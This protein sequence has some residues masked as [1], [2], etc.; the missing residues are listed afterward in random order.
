MRKILVVVAACFLVIPLRAQNK[1]S[2]EGKFTM[3]GYIK[4]SLSG[5]SIIG[6]SIIINGASKGVTSNQYGFYSITLDSG[7][8]VISVS[9][10]SYVSKAIRVNLD[11]NLTFDFDLIPKSASLNEVVIYSK[12]RDGNVKNAQMGKIDL[13]I[14]Q[15]K[16]IPALLG[17]VDI[18]KA[19][20]LL[21]G[22]Q[23]AGEGNAGF[24]VRGGGPDQNLIMLDDAVVYNTGHLFGFFSIF[25]SDAIKDVSL[26]K[27]GM[28]AQYGG[29]LSSVLDISMKDGNMNKTEME[30]GIGLIASRFSIQ[31]PIKK[32]KASYM[33]SVRR[34]YVDALV[35]P[36]IKKSSSFHGSGYYFYDLNAKVNYRFSEKD[37][38]YLSGY[39]GR[40]VFDFNN[41][42]QSFKTNIPWG[43]STATL[44][45]N[46]VFNRRLFANTTLV[47]NDYKFRFGAEQDNLAFSLSSG[48]RDGNMKIDFDYY[49]LPQHKVKFGGLITYHKFVPN[50][51]SGHQDSVVFHPN[52]ENNKYAIENALYLQDDWEISEKIKINYGLRWSG[53]TQIGPYTKYVR[54]INQNKTDSTV[55]K[56]FQPVKTYGGPEPRFTIRY[57]LNDETS[58]K[59]AVTRNYQYIHLVSNSGSTLPTDLWV[60]S[61]Y[62]VKPQLS[63]L[64]SAGIFK[65]FKNNEYETSL[66]L[67]YKDMKNQIEYSNGYMPSLTDPES[68]FVFGKG[69]SYGAEVFLNKVRGRFNGWIGYTLS[70]TWR[71]FKDLNNGEKYPAKYDRRHDLSIVAN[72]EKDKKWKFGAVFVFGTGNAVTLPDRFYIISGVLTQEYSQLNQYRMKPY[73]RLDL[74]ATYTPVPKKKKKIQS[75]WV[76]SIYNVYSRLNPYF[77]YFDQTG[78]PYNGTLQVQ[79]KQVSLFPI[80]PAVT[81][82]FKL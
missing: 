3:N 42:D 64:Y 21:P 25:N 2:Q 65:N 35:K 51:L 13:S 34:T 4:D 17:E 81:W 56:S 74:S 46:H 82:N 40:D 41:S 60:P 72:Y 52:D 59:A 54:D 7:T 19:I 16:N 76:F 10:I 78:S 68:E 29:R 27:G 18:L 5:E 32:N 26:I 53:F 58:L 62:I 6:A 28:P 57:S 67:Y 61:T 70:W 66:E 11:S 75:Y 37:R 30:G 22:I 50:V 69:W 48:I 49:P 15:I 39:F 23:N 47:Y 79:A 9:H 1:L 44:R 20:Q 45:W 73:H 55:Y 71:K 33:L 12:R 80:L 36:F 8:Y 14:G 43:N 31:G 24:Y 63:W 38:L 77:I